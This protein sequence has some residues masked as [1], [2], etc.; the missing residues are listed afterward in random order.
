MAEESPSHAVRCL[1][2][3][4]GRQV[5][6]VH[7]PGESRRI[8]KRWPL[9][10]LRA[11]KMLAGLSQPQRQIRGA[12][13]LG[14]AGIATPAPFGSCRISRPRRRPVVTIE[15][16]Y[17]EGETAWTILAD[18]SLTDAARIR[19]ARAVGSIVAEFRLA[20]LFNRDL[21]LTNLI[22][23]CAADEPIVQ[24]IDPVGVRRMGDEVEQTARMLERLAVLPLY[25]R[26]PLPRGVVI[27]SL[28]SALSG[29]PPAPRRAVL[30]RLRAHLTRQLDRWR[31]ASDADRR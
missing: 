5:W 23:D 17:V 8:V 16:E 3:E 1:K 11:I 27:A 30:R 2:A 20:G 13:R 10:V 15:L 31:T 7:R 12:G 9:T 25:H 24:V 4:G 26:V 29:L 21:K 28:R 14:R 22:I 18:D 19:C 6:L